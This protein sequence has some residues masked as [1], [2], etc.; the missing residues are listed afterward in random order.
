MLTALAIAR[1]LQNTTGLSIK[2]IIQTPRP[3]QQI[4]V[5]IAG[6]EHADTDPITPAAEA[7]LTALQTS[8]H[9][10]TPVA[11]VRSSQ[12]LGERTGGCRSRAGRST[13]SCRVRR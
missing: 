10:H 1:D 12:G 4:T 13:R 6:H 8:P 5:R 3:I 7:I 9:W 2:K 11:R